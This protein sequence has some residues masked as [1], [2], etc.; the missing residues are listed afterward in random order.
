MALTCKAL[1]SLV[2]AYLR[3]QCSPQAILPQLWSTGLPIGWIPPCNPGRIFG[4][5]LG[6]AT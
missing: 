6:H 4:E 1:K 3:A 5:G 2:P